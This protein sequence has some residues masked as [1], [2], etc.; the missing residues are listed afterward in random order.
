MILEKWLI[1]D[2][3]VENYSKVT[4]DLVK[5]MG[6]KALLCDIDNTLATY[7]D[8]TPPPELVEWISN[9]R[10]EGIEVAFVSNNDWDR[11]RGFNEEL[12]LVAYAK[13]G[14]PSRKHLK[15]AVN[16][17]GIDKRDAVLL[18]DQLLTDCAAGKRFGIPAIIVPPIKDKTTPFFKFKRWIEKPYMKK[19]RKINSGK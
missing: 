9:M 7:D 17:L 18:G 1:P 10:E 6:G 16:D 4:P 15:S 2:L 3:V 8:P 13:S 19:Y 11:V 12:H 14:K 5:S